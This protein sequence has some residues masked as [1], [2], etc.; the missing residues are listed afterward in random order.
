[1]LYALLR[2]LG[3]REMTHANNIDVFNETPHHEEQAEL[4]GFGSRLPAKSVVAMW[5]LLFVLAMAGIVQL[6]AETDGLRMLPSECRTMD[7]YRLLERRLTGLLPVEIIIHHR[8]NSMLA[9]RIAL[10]RQVAAYLR[11]DPN[12]ETVS[13][14]TELYPTSP[15]DAASAMRQVANRQQGDSFLGQITD[16]GRSWRLT[17]FVASAN[18]RTLDH[19]VS[20]L[21]A[22]L[23]AHIDVTVTGLVPLIVAAQGEIFDSLATSLVV[24]AVVLLVILWIA[25]RSITAAALIVLLNITPVTIVFGSLGWLGHPINMATLTTASIALGVALDDTLHLLENF[26]FHCELFPEESSEEIVSRTLRTCLSP[27]IKT[28]LIAGAG[29]A[30]MALSPFIPIAEFGCMLALLLAVALVGDTILLPAI[31]RTQ[32]GNCLRPIHHGLAV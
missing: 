1:L 29:M 2:N 9:T 31:L 22:D 12:I 21:E 7:D 28:T 26:R 3:W 10:T 11:S 8:D 6:T 5:P 25:F 18:G 32:L 14:S 13:D 27:M 4:S 30:S 23:A 17:A 15:Q 19:I 20:Q 24:A 16:D